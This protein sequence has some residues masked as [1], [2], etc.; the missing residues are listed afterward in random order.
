MTSLARDPPYRRHRFPPE[1]IAHAV[2]LYFRF[3][4]SLPMVEDMLAARGIIVSHQ[5]VRMWVEKLAS[6]LPTLDA[7]AR[8]AGS[9]TNGALTRSWSPLT[10]RDTG[11]GGPSIG[12]V[13]FSMFWCNAAAMPRLQSV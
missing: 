2:W 13:S 10:D 1:V 12:T 6:A 5:T 8:L 4:V 9:A 11:S 7:A 3:P